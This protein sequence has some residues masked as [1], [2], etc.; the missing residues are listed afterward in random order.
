MTIADFGI[1]VI[2]A[3]TC[4]VGSEFATAATVTCRDLSSGFG[5]V[6][7]TGGRNRAEPLA[8]TFHFPL[9]PCVGIASDGSCGTAVCLRLKASRL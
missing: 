9:H 2:L 1:Y 7:E 5:K 8:A 6:I 3:V 4:L